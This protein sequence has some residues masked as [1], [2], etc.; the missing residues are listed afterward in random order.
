MNPFH[1]WVLSNNNGHKNASAFEVVKSPRRHRQNDFQSE[2]RRKDPED[3]N[4]W[5]LDPVNNAEISDLEWQSPIER[6]K[7]TGHMKEEIYHFV[8]NVCCVSGCPFPDA[9][10]DFDRHANICGMR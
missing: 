8:H 6:W 1:K 5:Y 9:Y 3:V 10:W 4:A 7:R 2:E